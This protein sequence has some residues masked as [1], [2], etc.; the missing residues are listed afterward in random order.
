M[1]LTNCEIV[2]I[3]G[4]AGRTPVVI[5]DVPA[6]ASTALAD[7]VRHERHARALGELDTAAALALRALNDLAGR[8]DAAPGATMHV[9]RLDPADVAVV[10]DAADRYVAERDVDSY[11]P[12]EERARITALRD[13]RDS[14][15]DAQARLMLAGLSS[16]DPALT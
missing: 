6:E 5:A 12:P 7:A 10:A 11:Q 15:R 4:P 16:E 1:S 3:E 14:L 9:L 8:L 2:M 13:V